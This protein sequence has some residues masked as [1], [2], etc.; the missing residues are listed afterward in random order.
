MIKTPKLP[1]DAAEFCKD[2]A[3]APDDVLFFCDTSLFHHKTAA[4]LWEALLN[5]EGKMVIVP[6][7]RQELDPWLA[8]NGEHPAA[9]AILNG[10]PSVDF[11]GINPEDRRGKAAAEYYIE[12]LGFRKKLLI[13]ELATFE[14]EYGRPPDDEERRKLMARLHETL[15]PRGYL[16]AK[17]GGQ[18]KNS[19][20]LLTDETFVYLAMKTGIDAGG[21]GVALM[22]ISNRAGALSSAPWQPF[23]A[24]KR[25]RLIG[26][27]SKTKTVF[28]QY[29]DGAGNVS[30]VA[31]DRIKYRK[32]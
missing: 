2:V 13:L 11:S 26:A 3:G 10:E 27:G 6:P 23:V 19:E 1:H 15:G 29:R 21:S 24:S 31:L 5:R 25:W 28:V 16:L 18:A 4:R 17:K 20:N 22:R 12:L 32:R 8:S 14:E 9:Q 30:A 7:V